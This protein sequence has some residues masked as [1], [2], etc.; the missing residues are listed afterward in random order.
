M[1]VEGAL[2]PF[3]DRYVRFREHTET[4]EELAARIAGIEM[5]QATMRAS[6]MHLPSKF[7]DFAA[8][9]RATLQRVAQS[10]APSPPTPPHQSA[11]EQAVLALHNNASALR[12][13][14]RGAPPCLLGL[15]FLGAGGIGALA[16]LIVLGIR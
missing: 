4:K 12:E 3:D 2:A 5:E 11:V 1:S 10:T 13:A 6:L 16:L 14:G 7:D 15:A 9:M 8:E